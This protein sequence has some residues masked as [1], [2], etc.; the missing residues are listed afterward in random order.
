M[1]SWQRGASLALLAPCLLL[2]GSIFLPLLAAR[3]ALSEQAGGRFLWQLPVSSLV[4]PGVLALSPLSVYSPRSPDTSR[5]VETP[6]RVQQSQTSNHISRYR[7]R[8][9]ADT[10]CREVPWGRCRW[11]RW[12]VRVRPLRR[13]LA[14]NSGG[15]SWQQ[16]WRALSSTHKA[17]QGGG[18][19]TNCSYLLPW[20]TAGLAWE[21]VC[22]AREHLQSALGPRV[23]SE[24]PSL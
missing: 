24:C 10:E 6:A 8:E 7:E 23:V 12:R 9:K 17:S 18:S 1:S 16:Q 21:R 4:S 11:Y 3:Q 5:A 20:K 15:F 13:H 2:Q 14:H 22:P 19:A